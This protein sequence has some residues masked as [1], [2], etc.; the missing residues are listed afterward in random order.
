[1]LSYP[2]SA[3]SDHIGPLP[4]CGL[5]TFIEGDAVA[6]EK[7][8]K[9]A[10]AGANPALAVS[11][12]VRSGCSAIWANISAVNFSS[13][14]TL[15]PRGFGSA[16]PLSCQRCSHLT[17]ELALISKRS[18]GSRRDA[19]PPQL[20]S[21]VLADHQNQASASATPAKENQC[22]K[23]RSSTSWES[24]RFKSAGKPF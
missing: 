2:T 20:Q 23:T 15:P 4:S 12:K 22:T 7:T 16:L 1:L 6:I 11:S 8:P 18:P 19:L 3:R 10:A 5:Q 9:R 14:K 17:D 13:G 24:R 21:P